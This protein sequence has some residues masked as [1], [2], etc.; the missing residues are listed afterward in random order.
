MLDGLTSPRIY[1]DAPAPPLVWPAWLVSMKGG[2]LAIQRGVDNSK[3]EYLKATFVTSTPMTAIFTHYE[4][5]LNVNDY[6]VHNS[7]LETGQT[8]SGIAQNANGYVEGSNYP[9]GNPGPYTAIHVSFRR[10]NLNDP[11]TVE[12]RIT[13]FPYEGLKRRF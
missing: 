2:K 6:R 9:S 3:R 8:I 7:R 13:A 10:S 1:E 12:L 5:L 4:D 11:I